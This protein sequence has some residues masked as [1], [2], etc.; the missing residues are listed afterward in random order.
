MDRAFI[1]REIQRTAKENGGEPLGRLQFQRETGIKE[2]DWRGRWWARWNEAVIEAGYKPNQLTA[3]FSEDLLLE[4]L[5][6]LARELGRFPTSSERRLKKRQD[7]TFPNDKVFA[8]LGSKAQ[9]VA[10]VFAYCNDRAGYEDVAAL[11]PTLLSPSR[12]AEFTGKQGV[13]ATFGFVYLI[14]SGK[15]FKI[16]RSNSVGRRE[17]ELAIQLPEKASEVHAI[18]TDDP[19]GIEAYWHK[20]FEAKRKNGEWFELSREDI[21]AFKR[22]KFM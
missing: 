8:R 4:K 17:Y 6:N 9:L 12:A 22:R 11:C 19:V 15:H 7:A 2:S 21:S 20:R 3:A 14:K 1:L 13:K 18:R 5:A 16:G 10:R